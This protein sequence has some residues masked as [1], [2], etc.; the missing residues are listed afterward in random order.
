MRLGLIDVEGGE[1]MKLYMEVSRDKYSLP[2]TIAD[3]PTELAKMTGKRRE[4]I[5]CAISRYK[6]GE[7]K[8]PSFIVVEVED[9]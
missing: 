5:L 9:E 4:N 2:L 7:V 6:N 3:S 1:G 8:I